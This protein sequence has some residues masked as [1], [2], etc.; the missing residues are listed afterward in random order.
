MPELYIGMM[1]GISADGIDAV[2]AEIS[3]HCHSFRLL[4]T[5]HHPFSAI[6][7][8]RI[9]SLF[10]PSDNEIDRLGELDRLLGELYGE[11]ALTLLQQSGISANAITA[12]GN[13]GQTIRH[14]PSYSN[15]FTLQI[16]G[17]A[18]VAAITGIPVISDFRRADV[19]QGGQG[20]PLAPGFHQALFRHVSKSSCIINIGGIANVTLL[21]PQNQS[22]NETVTGWD[23]GPGNGLMDAWINK[24]QA[25]TFDDN[26]HW[27]AKGRINHELLG[28]LLSHPYF[29][30][31]PPKSTGKEEFTLDWVLSHAGIHTIAAVDVQRTLLELTALTIA[32]A[33]QT[34]TIATAYICG[35]GAYNQTLLQRL[36]ELCP[37]T[38]ISTTNDLGIAP[39][40]VE[41]AAFAWLAHQFWHK[42]PG[43][44]P[45]VTGARKATVLG[46]L[47]Y[48]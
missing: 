41:A 43:N 37:N 26:G 6:I 19:A 48:P 47:T 36:A 8:Q 12:I 30:K 34:H 11:C 23:T 22:I 5:Y 40:W 38:H 16:G 27:A 35:G 20:A 13:H 7:K 15:P 18:T 25:L 39:T 4:A 3:Q 1:S 9:E 17:A 21:P 24:H 10:T 32:T 46:S 28:Q 14:R 45:S 29:T 44:I 2:V 33:L 42:L 31:Q